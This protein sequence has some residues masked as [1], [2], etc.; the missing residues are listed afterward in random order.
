MHC[1]LLGKPGRISALQRF[2]DHVQAHEQGLDRAAGSTSPATGTPVHPFAG[3]RAP[4]AM[5]GELAMSRDV[6]D[7]SHFASAST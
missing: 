5:V 7:L 2:L 1:R 4:P 6:L 3:N